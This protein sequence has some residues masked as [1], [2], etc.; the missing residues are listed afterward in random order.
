M[1]WDFVKRGEI[2]SSIAKGTFNYSKY[3]PNSKNALRFGYKPPSNI[4]VGEML[5]TYLEEVKRTL[6]FSTYD[7]YVKK[8]IAI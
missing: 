2:L 4:T 3:F 6:E 1:V 8:S 5:N 7:S